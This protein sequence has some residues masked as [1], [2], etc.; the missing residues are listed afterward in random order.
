MGSYAQGVFNPRNPE[1]YLGR[2]SIRYRSSWE[3]AVMNML[4]NHPAITQWASENIR[5]PYKN[6][7]TGKVTHY[8]PDFFVLFIDSKD[9][10]HGEVWE[11]K[12]KKEVAM[13]NVKSQRDKIA[14][15]VNTAK[16]Q[17]ATA[18]CKQNGLTFRVITEE[19]LFFSGR[20]R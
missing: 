5:I 7:I 18:W 2:G 10:T 4:D 11:I 8:V 15:V 20:K 16:W 3:W 6:P 1:K 14:V 19:Q 17:A 12:P 9:Q 13:E